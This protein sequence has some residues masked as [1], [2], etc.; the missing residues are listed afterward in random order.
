MNVLLLVAALNVEVLAR[1]LNLPFQERRAVPTPLPLKL[2][3]TL[4]AHDPRFSLALIDRRS[5][6]VGDELYGLTVRSISRGCVV[7]S[8][9]C[10]SEAGDQELCM[11]PKL[12]ASPDGAHASSGL[13]VPLADFARWMNVRIA[14]VPDG[15]K[16]FGIPPGSLY[17]QLGVKS[18]DTV[19]KVNGRPVDFSVLSLV[20]PGA[21]LTVELERNGQPYVLEGQL[22]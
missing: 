6:F 3:G 10:A 21:H 19:R 7:L 8:A 9:P 13:H 15:F 18:G 12:A 11:Q 16:V 14:P 22:D 20:H 5:V 1:L 2:H 17:E 4:V